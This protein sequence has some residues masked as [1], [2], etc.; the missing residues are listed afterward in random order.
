MDPA[1]RKLLETV[2]EAFE[3]AG[4]P[5]EKLSGSKT[6]CFVG[7]FNRDHSLKQYHDAE[8]PEPYSMTGGGDA[9]L[10]NRVNYVFNLHGPSLTLDTACSSSLYA[11]HLAC[12]AIQNRECDGAIVA[13][14]N[15]ILM[16]DVQIFSSSL[17]TVSPTSR[18]HT[19]DIAADGYARA[20]GIGALYIK[21]MADAINDRD[22]IRAI[23][24]GTAVNA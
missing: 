11:L 20:D 16:P 9:I 10:S 14:S 6:G 5:L 8:Y 17:G 24:R 12:S 19:F 18:C 15:L 3:S 1:Q 2:Y 13:A 22:P 4:V 7:N 21:R 23:I